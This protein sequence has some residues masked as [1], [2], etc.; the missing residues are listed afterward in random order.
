MPGILAYIGLVLFGI[1]SLCGLFGLSF[2]NR[3]H[4]GGRRLLPVP[5]WLCWFF[6]SL[7]MAQADL[8][9]QEVQQV[10]T[11]PPLIH[12]FRQDSGTALDLMAHIEFH[13][14]PAAEQGQMFPHGDAQQ[15][16]D[17]QF[18]IGHELDILLEYPGEQN[19]V[20]YRADPLD[21]QRPTEVGR[22][23]RD[24]TT[25]EEMR[26]FL[27]GIWPDLRQGPWELLP[28]DAT[29]HTSPQSTANTI[30]LLIWAVNDLLSRDGTA[31]ITL[32]EHQEWNLKTAMVRV[33]LTPI[34]MWRQTDVPTWM[35][36]LGFSHL[37]QNS[38]CVVRQNGYQVGWRRLLRSYDAQHITLFSVEEALQVRRIILAP[39]DFE[40]ILAS[41]VPAWFS[42]QAMVGA[43]RHWPDEIDQV[44][45]SA[46]AL[47][48]SLSQMARSIFR[49]TGLMQLTTNAVAVA[50]PLVGEVDF[51][52]RLHQ[53]RRDPFGLYFDLLSANLASETMAWIVMPIHPSVQMSR[54]S[55]DF[56]YAGIYFPSQRP[57]QSVL[58]LVEILV[59]ED[60]L[61]APTMHHQ[62]RWLPSSWTGHL[63]PHHELPIDNIENCDLIVNGL[64]TPLHAVVRARDGCFIHLSCYPRDQQSHIQ[65][66]RILVPDET[67]GDA[68]RSAKRARPST[69]SS[70][71]TTPMGPPVGLDVAMTAC[72][73]LLSR[74]GRILHPICRKECP[75]SGH[76]TKMYSTC[77]FAWRRHTTF[78]VLL[79]V[80]Q[81]LHVHGLQLRIGEAQNP[82]PEIWVGTSN[83][84]GI[85]TKEYV[86][87]WL[88]TGIWGVSES[89]LTQLGQRQVRRAFATQGIE[90]GRSYSCSFGHPVE[91]R[92]RSLEAGTWAGVMLLGQASFRAVNLQWPNN[93]FEQGRVQVSEAWVG[94]FSTLITNIYGWSKGPTWPKAHTMTSQMLDTVTKEVILSRN[95]PR[96]VMG[97]LNM[98]QED[99][100]HFSLWKSLGWVEAQGWAAQMLNRAPIATSKNATRVDHLWLSPELQPFLKDV[101]VWQ[102]FSDHAAVGA[103]LSVPLQPITQLI[104]HMPSYIP[105]DKVAFPEWQ[106]SSIPAL[107]AGQ[108][109][110]KTFDQF[111]RYYE[112]SF[113]G[114]MDSP[115]GNLPRSCYGRGSTLTPQT[116]SATFPLLRPSRPGEVAQPTELLGRHVQQWFR[117]LR[118]LQS[119][120]HGLRAAKDTADAVAYRLELW[121]AIKRA[122]GF[123]NGFDGWWSQRPV[124]LQG[125]PTTL[126]VGVP[127][128]EIAELLF[129]DFQVNYRKFESW[130]ARQR[131]ALL[132]VTFQS[133][134]SKIFGMIKPTGKAPLTQLEEVHSVHV[135]AQSDDGKQIQV[136]EPLDLHLPYTIKHE[137]FALDVEEIQNDIII[138]DG[139]TLVQPGTQLDATQRYVT[140][141]EIHYALGKYWS[142]RWW[143]EPPPPEAWDRIFAFARAYL[144]RGH[145]E[146]EPINVESWSLIN[147]RYTQRAAGGP[148]GFSAKDLQWM[149]V[150]LKQQLVDQ[151]NSWEANGTW[152]QQLLT[153]FV[154]P[155]PK[156]EQ[157]FGVGDFRPV[158][159]YSAIYRSWSSLRARTMLRY[160]A[161]Y[162]DC[163]QFGFL[164]GCE[165]A[166]IWLLLQGMLELSHQQSLTKVGYVTDLVKAFESLPRAPIRILGEWLGLPPAAMAFVLGEHASSFPGG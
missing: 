110:T 92:A 151:L 48:I 106:D 135:L 45:R 122:K 65:R 67:T 156:R 69:P 46:K 75:L 41:N 26:D 36:F 73:L 42:A 37:C 11:I 104:W 1:R 116:R 78:L 94:P 5:Y 13:Q 96:V 141:P 152:P 19:F 99:S 38:P 109:P 117:Q 71:S 133:Q 147:K 84:S 56:E 50:T 127:T 138:T 105:W 70:P 72:L 66:T 132:Q 88:P 80:F 166:E 139:D 108:P 18:R 68:S 97:D 145:L 142:D 128:V 126:P 79:F 8:S 115:D 123:Q 164:P 91:P 125:T 35:N 159:V 55:P 149:P 62:M 17:E 113:D 130:H 137:D 43:Q 81:A 95:G 29:W 86:Y 131:K 63:L 144:P 111:C 119:L 146:M 112:Q 4:R 154:H 15:G 12:T 28:V 9:V 148:D 32:V 44:V 10:D 100:S 59:H 118:R 57:V 153:G 40:E 162:A 54:L 6:L 60:I 83:P 33:S 143:K 74:L 14:T 114:Y 136:P 90:T 16:L 129:Q 134:Q 61:Q 93:E 52:M 31:C 102:Y 101:K 98:Q 89:Q 107:D 85:R 155:L 21:T 87:N 7:G 160:L 77:T 120:L 58:I 49:D 76:I 47:Q 51:I 2:G 140:P 161:T 27:Y 124:Q 163:H 23:L 158:I 20:I 3:L 25:I 82:G 64:P 165:P 53:V 24:S 30:P 103:Q 150:T 157:S 34:S 22:S 39:N 121:S